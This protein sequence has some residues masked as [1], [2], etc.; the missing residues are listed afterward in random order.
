MAHLVMGYLEVQC[1]LFVRVESSRY[2][3]LWCNATYFYL[4]SLRLHNEIEYLIWY[5]QKKT[6]MGKL[7]LLHGDLG[8]RSKCRKFQK[9]LFSTQSKRVP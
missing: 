5:I 6:E 1:I 7:N 4:S 8:K 9:I 3:S 2:T